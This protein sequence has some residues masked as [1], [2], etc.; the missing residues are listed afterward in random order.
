ML[1][2]A[3]ESELFEPV[4]RG[5]GNPTWH[6]GMTTPNPQGRGALPPSVTW[7]DPGVRGKYLI[8]K[9]GVK[10]ILKFAKNIKK[11]PLSTHDAQIVAQIARSLEDGAELERFQNRTFG[12]VPDKQINLNMNIDAT[13]EQLSERALE[14]LARISD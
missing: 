8:Q 3:E 4:K 11:A 6:K 14:L 7:Q 10:E 9:Y 13:P 12:K 5:K 1:I 2:S